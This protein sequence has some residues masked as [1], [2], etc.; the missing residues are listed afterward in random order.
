MGKIY[1]NSVHIITLNLKKD[2]IRR[3]ILVKKNQWQSRKQLLNLFFLFTSND[4]FSFKKITGTSLNCS[5]FIYEYK[6]SHSIETLSMFGHLE[7]DIQVI[8]FSIVQHTKTD[9]DSHLTIMA[10]V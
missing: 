5:E 10:F 2:K 6:Y 1:I 9:T 4:R 8:R 7:V 3:K